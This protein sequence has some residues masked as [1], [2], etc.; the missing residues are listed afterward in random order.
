MCCFGVN[1]WGF[2]DGWF[3]WGG[4]GRSKGG[5]SGFERVTGLIGEAGLLACSNVRCIG[6]EGN[7]EAG[8][9]EEEEG[10]RVG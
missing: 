8:E 2:E 9:E 7:E 6:G 10:G 4:C 1:R 3:D 5:W